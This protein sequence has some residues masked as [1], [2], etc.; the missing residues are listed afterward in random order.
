[1][2]AEDGSPMRFPQPFTTRSEQHNAIVQAGKEYSHSPE[3]RVR[4]IIEAEISPATLGPTRRFEVH[5][6]RGL[7]VLANNQ[8]AFPPEF[9]YLLDAGL[10]SIAGVSLA[11]HIDGF[12]DP[13][14]PDFTL[15]QL[16]TVQGWTPN[17]I[18]FP[19]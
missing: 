2:Q 5:Y 8:V 16:M 15:H 11:Y 13:T 14:F 4:T 7:N 6:I 10:P 12:G 9:L 1:M 19:A 18:I 3:E 17:A